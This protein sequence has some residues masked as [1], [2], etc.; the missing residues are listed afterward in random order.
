MIGKTLI[1]LSEPDTLA[2][3]APGSDSAD[4]KLEV[5]AATIGRINANIVALATE[6]VATWSSV[7]L[8]TSQLANTFLDGSLVATGAIL[9]HNLD[10]HTRRRALISAAHATGMLPQ[11]VELAAH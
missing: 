6:V 9:Q 4:V 3:L 7:E 2:S 10:R 5:G 8:T 1:E 11:D